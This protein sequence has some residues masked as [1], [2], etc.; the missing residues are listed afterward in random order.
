MKIVRLKYKS[1]TGQICEAYF[2]KVW[3]KYIPVIINLEV[4][5]DTNS[6]ETISE[7]EIELDLLGQV[8]DKDGKL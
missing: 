3:N 8:V 5:L 2:A 1:N 7:Q 6:I 4:L